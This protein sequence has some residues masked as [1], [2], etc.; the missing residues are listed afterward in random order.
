MRSASRQLLLGTRL[1]LCA[2]SAPT[3]VRG[4][5]GSM[6][7]FHPGHN[8]QKTLN[9]AVLH[10]CRPY[11]RLTDSWGGARIS[12]HCRCRLCQCLVNRRLPPPPVV[13]I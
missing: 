2:G 9:R 11:F 10:R 8:G 3:A 13:S 7:F 1:W 4:M 5:L 12:M 6:H